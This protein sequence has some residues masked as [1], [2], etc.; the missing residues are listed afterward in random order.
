MNPNQIR[1]LN[2]G[3]M[4]KASEWNALVSAAQAM[5]PSHN[6]YT[7]PT[8]HADKR[9]NVHVRKSTLFYTKSAIPAYSIFAV[10]TPDFEISA[11]SQPF[12]LAEVYDN[13]DRNAFFSADFGTNGNVSIPE[14]SLF[15]GYIVSE[16]YDDIVCVSDLNEGATSCGF[17][18]G[19]FSAS[20]KFTGLRITKHFRDY[21]YYVR[22]N[23]EIPSEVFG[24]LSDDW[25]AGDESAII[26]L[27]ED[28]RIDGAEILEAFPAPTVPDSLE[29]GEA[30]TCRFVKAVGKWFF[31][32]PAQESGK[33]VYFENTEN[34]SKFYYSN[35]YVLVP[36]GAPENAP[37]LGMYDIIKHDDVAIIVP[38]YSLDEPIYVY[39]DN[40]IIYEDSRSPTVEM[41]YDKKISDEIYTDEG[42]LFW[43]TDTRENRYF[44]T[45][46]DYPICIWKRINGTITYSKSEY[47]WNDDEKRYYLETNQYET[48]EE[49]ADVNIDGK[50]FWINQNQ[51]LIRTS[52]ADFYPTA[53]NC[54]TGEHWEISDWS[55][56]ETLVSKQRVKFAKIQNYNSKYFLHAKSWGMSNV[57]SVYIS[58]SGEAPKITYYL[59]DRNDENTPSE[60]IGNY[61][62]FPYAPENASLYGYTSAQIGTLNEV[63]LK[64]FF[65]RKTWQFR[66]KNKDP[67]E[68]GAYILI[69]NSGESSKGLK[70]DRNLTFK[71]YGFCSQEFSAVSYLQNP[72]NF[73]IT[74]RDGMYIVH[75]NEILGNVIPDN[76]LSLKF[77]YPLEVEDNDESYLTNEN[78]SES[79]TLQDV[80]DGKI[81]P[82]ADGNYATKEIME[83]G[84]IVTV[85]LRTNANYWCKIEAYLGAGTYKQTLAKTEPMIK[86][87]DIT[88]TC[89][90]GEKPYI[91]GRR[92]ASAIVFDI[93]ERK[94][95]ESENQ[96]V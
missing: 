30:V 43:Y 87:N 40:F 89:E 12:L 22:R 65:N 54:Q 68:V 66:I 69:G 35:G 10:K 19:S 58:N 71:F 21:L 42:M 84:K 38:E 86:R 3:Q 72:D 26:Q 45:P 75:K 14:N 91:N 59:G 39:N 56:N 95:P 62:Y 11:T 57:R 64:T 20:G 7:T 44:P 16:H 4:P 33:K 23:F 13:S 76:M 74:I 63:N 67:K 55:E 61:K 78:V 36:N 48:E 9:E 82:N 77:A 31:F 81:K 52:D 5:N 32:R 6:G 1:N 28:F 47:V 34:S 41:F 25:R 27:D 94:L 46:V 49:F 90:L 88:L 73:E 53:H 80:L 24:T 29:A 8:G 96:N 17:E 50:K 37:M 79:F 85:D 15:Y 60:T 93:P 2:P 51:D 70:F 92:C 18:S 83:D